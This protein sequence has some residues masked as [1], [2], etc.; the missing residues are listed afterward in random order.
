MLEQWDGGEKS[1]CIGFEV[2]G[3]WGRG[4]VSEMA[5]KRA[6]CIKRVK[7]WLDGGE[8]TEGGVASL[9][10]RIVW[11]KMLAEG[12]ITGGFSGRAVTQI[13]LSFSK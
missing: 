11:S 4:A 6:C 3:R 5:G 9:E 7:T 1:G 10:G 8:S 2:Q 12:K 13:C